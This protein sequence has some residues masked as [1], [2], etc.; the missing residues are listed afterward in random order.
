VANSTPAGIKIEYDSST[1]GLVDITQYVLTINEI[2][3]ESLTE[4]VHTFGDSWEEHLPIG[5][6]KMAPV[7]LGGLYESSTSGI[8]GLF[9]NR[10]PESPSSST[11]TLKFTWIAS[12]NNTSVETY[13]SNY[14]R[15]PDRNALT[16]Y[17]AKLQ[18]TGTVTESTS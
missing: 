15:A 12:G 7:E 8:N 17:K 4:E 16:K 5:V 1:G 9:C 2:D 6:G 18:P 10:A 11:R 3:V 14:N 13:L